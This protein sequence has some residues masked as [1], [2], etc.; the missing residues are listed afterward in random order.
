MQQPTE[1]ISEIERI[2]RGS[3]MKLY[4]SGWIMYLIGMPKVINVNLLGSF[5]DFLVLLK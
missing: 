1:N 5:I 4:V 2:L 3:F